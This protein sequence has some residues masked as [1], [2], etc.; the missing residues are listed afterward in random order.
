[1]KIQAI[2]LDLDGTLLNSERMISSRTKN[3]LIKAQQLGIKVMIAS[4]RSANGLRPFAEELELH[5]Y[6]GLLI[7][8][9]GAVV[10]DPNGQIT[11]LNDT[12]HIPAMQK[13]IQH[14]R[15]YDTLTVLTD[16]DY[17]YATNVESAIIQT[18][19]G[20][21]N[22]VE[23]ESIDCDLEIIELE[24]FDNFDKPISKMMVVSH[25][26][27]MQEH[28]DTI[29]APV[30]EKISFEYTEPYFVEFM[31]KGTNKANGLEAALNVLNIPRENTIAFGDGEND[32]SII[33]HAGIGVAMGNATENILQQ[34]DFTTH[35]NDEDG[36][37]TFL[38]E[39]VLTTIKK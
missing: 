26:E 21:L 3:T 37:A 33:Q 15:N 22:V 30:K 8:N 29:V 4:G 14:A 16:H 31:K 35:S 34:S 36:I 6:G 12:I 38:E 25:E 24:H 7:S 39:K 9:N 10:Q 17:I 2:A 18:E 32:L 23:A 5:K 13:L 20:P 19:N 27:Y 1:M 11:Y 28:R